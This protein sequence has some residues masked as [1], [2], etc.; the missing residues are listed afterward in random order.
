MRILLT[1]A[2][3]FIGYYLLR[4]LRAAGHEVIPTTRNPAAAGLQPMDVTDPFAVHD[5]FE[6]WRPEAVLHAGAM[7]R[8][9]DCEQR[10]WEAYVTNVEGTLNL[11]VNAE[12]HRSFF[13]F[14]STDFVFDG[15]SGMYREEDPP[16]PINFYGKTKLEA[17]QAVREYPGD[18]SIVRTIMVYGHPFSGRDNLV[19]L[20]AR[21]LKAGEPYSVFQDQLRTPTYV[22]DLVSAIGEILSRRANGLFHVSG[23]EPLTPYQMACRTAG[24]LGLD[25]SLIHPVTSETLKQPARRPPKTGFDISRASRELD[26]RPLPFELGLQK[27]FERALSS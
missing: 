15:R 6:Q 19:S 2:K 24:F 22:E 10:Q 3:G 12:E 4:A 13:V 14:L 1:G 11:L 18:W 17:E 20:V 25:S 7:S 21:K 16:N 9:D 8:P 26:F 27:T 23:T 5:C